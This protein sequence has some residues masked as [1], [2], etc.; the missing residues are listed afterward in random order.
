MKKINIFITFIT[1]LLFFSCATYQPQ[2]SSTYQPDSFSSDGK[3]I[4]R[5]FYLIGDAGYISIG[6]TE[7]NLTLQAFKNY[8]AEKNT[9][10]NNLLFLGNSFYPKGMPE[11]DGPV[12]AEAKQKIKKQLEAIEGFQGTVN[13]LPGNLDWKS[14]VDGLELEE[15]LLKE[16][17]NSDSVLEPNNGCPLE[18]VEIND[19][20]HLI[21][22]DTQ[23]YIE[24]WDKH[25]KMN[26]KCQIKN[27]AK[28]LVELEGELK[29][30]KQKTIILAMHH[31]LYTNGKHGGKFPAK[32]HLLPVPGLASLITASILA[33]NTKY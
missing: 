25:P 24:N 4:E 27:R 12:K 8:I 30:A 20:V 14:S 3:E 15:D 6:E 2:Y 33:F 9:E 32:N 22:I 28:F 17:L 19:S 7:K 29:K 18:E 26:D 1:A 16:A 5:T 10:D 11:D 31:P 23:W 13:V 21:M